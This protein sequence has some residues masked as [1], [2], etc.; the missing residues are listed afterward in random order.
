MIG[1]E[2]RHLLNTHYRPFQWSRT[3]NPESYDKD[4]DGAIG[5]YIAPLAIRRPWN[6]PIN[7]ICASSH[8][9]SRAYT[10]NLWCNTYTTT[11]FFVYVNSVRQPPNQ[12][13]FE[14]YFLTIDH[15]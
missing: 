6:D 8:S 10:L 4:G 15:Y 14:T 1:L 3:S 12:T 13:R 9:T 7:L 11:E 5:I 2:D